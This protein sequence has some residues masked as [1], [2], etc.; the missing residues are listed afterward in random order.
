M[1]KESG[2]GVHNDRQKN[3][4]FLKGFDSKNRIILTTEKYA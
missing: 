1:E 2:A 4:P 3:S